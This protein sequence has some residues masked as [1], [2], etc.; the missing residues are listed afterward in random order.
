MRMLAIGLLVAPFWISG[1]YAD[2]LGTASRFAAPARPTSKT[3]SP[4]LPAKLGAW[5]VPTFN[6]IPLTSGNDKSGL[7][8]GSLG[9]DAKGGSKV[10]WAFQMG[11]PF[12]TT[13]ASTAKTI[14]M[15][16]LVQQGGSYQMLGANTAFQGHPVKL[17]HNF[18]PI[19]KNLVSDIVPNVP[20]GFTAVPEP[21]T[22]LVLLGFCLVGLAAQITRRRAKAGVSEA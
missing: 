5:T 3:W 4:V 19:N 9:I 8:T 2:I 17:K 22:P 16:S 21:R 10:S 6:R 14:N 15:Q 7:L 20:R 13:H 1:A 18:V 11:S 12:T